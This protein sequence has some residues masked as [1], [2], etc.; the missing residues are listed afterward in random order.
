MLAKTKLNSNETWISDALIRLEIS[1]EKFKTIINYKTLKENIR[2]MK[3]NELS[4][5]KNISEEITKM[6]KIKK[7]LIFLPVIKC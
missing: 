2:M 3:Y 1:H 4:E 7:M 5:S 6:G